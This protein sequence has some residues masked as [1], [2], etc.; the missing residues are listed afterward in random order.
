MMLFHS[1]IRDCRRISISAY[2][3]KIRLQLAEK[4]SDERCSSSVFSASFRS[5]FERI[6]SKV[7][8]ATVPIH[9]AQAQGTIPNSPTLGDII[10]VT[11]NDAIRPAIIFLF[12]LATV[13]FIWG[14]VEFIASA[15]NEE[16]R[17]RG[18]RTI[19]WGI[20]G[21]TI[22][23]VTGAIMVVIDNFFKAL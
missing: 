15:E 3:L 13:V 21:M 7:Y 23:V 4:Y 22:M 6:S 19:V 20:I 1:L 18:K 17:T 8:S 2:S 12:V 11:W 16:G 9:I 10:R 5:N 14:L